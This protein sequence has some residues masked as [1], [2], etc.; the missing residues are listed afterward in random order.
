[1]MN[2]K[3]R[4]KAE[5]MVDEVF[6]LIN[7]QYLYHRINRPI[8]EAA[9]SFEFDRKAQV[10]HHIF[11]R[12]TSNFV[13]HIYKMGFGIQQIMSDLQAHSKAVSILETEYRN[14]NA[15]GYHAAFLDAINP[16]LNGLD[17]VLTQMTE[18]ITTRVRIKYIR[19]V[20]ATRVDS[21]SWATRLLIAEIL[22]KR[23]EPF[24]PHGILEC[25]PAQMADHLPELIN[26]LNS[27]NEA[28]R[29]IMGYNEYYE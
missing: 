26:V 22:L 12:V 14:L 7:E 19:W 18:I 3:P 15:K 11:Q 28:A 20:Y 17:V 9:L 23:W 21:L 4:A 2:L 5:K 10:T 8:E 13:R 29:N 24:L 1:M 27:T 6:K 16:Q 25:C